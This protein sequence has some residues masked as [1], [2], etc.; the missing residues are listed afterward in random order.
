MDTFF[1][2][3]SAVEFNTSDTL[4]LW[5][6]IIILACVLGSIYLFKDSIK[7][8]AFDSDY[9]WYYIIAIFNLVNISAIVYY[10]IYHSGKYKGDMGSKGH[11]GK[12]GKRGKFITCSYCKDNLYMERTSVYE[13]IITLDSTFEKGLSEI[14][15][16]EIKLALGSAKVSISEIDPASVIESL[17]NK[18]NKSSASVVYDYFMNQWNQFIPN[19]VNH[20]NSVVIGKYIDKIGSFSRPT[21]KEGYFPLGDSAFNSATSNKM[22]GFMIAGNVRNPVRYE[23]ISP[24]YVPIEGAD[25]NKVLQSMKFL[26][27]VPPEGFVA[28]GDAVQRAGK[29]LPTNLFGC[30]SAECVKELPKSDMECVFA[31]YSLKDVRLIWLLPAIDTLINMDLNQLMF[32]VW[33]T[34]M[35]TIYI[36]TGEE[37]ANNTLAF[38]I[39]N[40]SSDYLNDAGAVTDE[41]IET[42]K[43]R[44]IMMTLTDTLRAFI[45]TAY[46]VAKLIISL[47]QKRGEYYNQL[48]IP[49]RNRAKK[50]NAKE[51][52]EIRKNVQIF[53]DKYTADII[54]STNN[55]IQSAQNAYDVLVILFGSNM[56]LLL[57]ID[58]AG[59]NNGGIPMFNVQKRYLQMLKMLFPPNRPVYILKNECIAYYRVDEKRQMLIGELDNVMNK[60]AFLKQKYLENPGQQCASLELVNNFQTKIFDDLRGYMVGF[61]DFERQLSEKSFENFNDNRLAYIIKKFKEMNDVI[62]GKCVSG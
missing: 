7:S 43:E 21:A 17:F 11:K 60:Y 8:L 28:L 22:S 27:I 13:P 36:N 37:F 15:N 42:I 52:A 32:T 29:T 16:D 54:A 19:V 45:I 25:Y 10:Y 6:V 33:R 51:R 31:H 3:I 18:N 35:N 58:K 39:I 56:N 59:F 57:S 24:F 4:I 44:L 14:E 9:Y 40:G 20:I 26:R 34:P 46:F 50:P 55:G 30:V 38:N 5:V 2:S 12:K 62:S 48:M 23:I 47:S 61:P 41:M 49:F 53:S 1:N